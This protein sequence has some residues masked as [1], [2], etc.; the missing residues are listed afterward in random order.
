MHLPKSRG[1]Y[2]LDWIQEDCRLF[3]RS[4]ITCPKWRPEVA[5]QQS[6][7]LMTLRY[8]HKWQ[9]DAFWDAGISKHV[10][11]W[12]DKTT[13]IINYHNSWQL[14]FIRA[15]TSEY[16]ALLHGKKII[17]N[18]LILHLNSLQF[19]QLSHWQVLAALHHSTAH[20]CVPLHCSF[21]VV[22]MDRCVI[23]FQC[24]EF[25]SLLAFECALCSVT[26]LALETVAQEVK[27]VVHWS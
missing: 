1:K 13:A 4:M 5:N 21:S 12:L 8:N 23:L 15:G 20:A 11:T 22:V 9:R 7:N 19:C 6:K 14:I 2:R 18:R 25:L 26:K 24:P 17:K 27:Q 3:S 10:T 16:L